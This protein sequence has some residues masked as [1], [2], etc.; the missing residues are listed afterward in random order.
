MSEPIPERFF[1]HS[2]P[3]RGASTAL[4]TQKGK[5]ILAAIRDFG[6]VLTPEFIEW[7]QPT[8][9]GSP[10]T[11]P[12]LQKR[13]CF[14]ELSP[15]ELPP[16]AE[17]FGHFA[18]EFEIDAVRRLGAMPVFYVPQPTGEAAD[19]SLVGAA[20]VAIATD[21]RA[22]VQRMASLNEVLHGATPVHPKFNFNVGFADSPDGRGNFTIDRD[23]AKNFLT[24]IGHAVTPWSDLRAGADALLNFFHP[25]DNK[26]TDKVLE[27][28]REREWRIACGLR[29]K[30]R[31]GHPDVDLLRS[32]TPDERQRL[33]QIDHQFFSRKIKNGAGEADTLD[34]ALVLPG[35]LSQCLIQMVRRVI[36]PAA[37]VND[38]RE[39]LRIVDRPPPVISLDEVAM[40]PLP[41]EKFEA[42]AQRGCAA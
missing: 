37:A 3:R 36:V 35:L 24:A 31:D 14:T 25:T 23:E 17:K 39:L 6:L 41:K 4:E 5:Q 33:L 16:H 15:S 26:E 29:L 42:H 30:G 13:V 18:L 32:L 2:F 19:G 12:I 1:Y 38:V 7:T 10:R 8:L 9:G 40:T 20:L 22:V 11:L 34:Q 21:L 27:Y 28:Y